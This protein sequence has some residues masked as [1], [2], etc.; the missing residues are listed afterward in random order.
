MVLVCV[1][2]NVYGL[3]F[4]G[5]DEVVVSIIFCLVLFVIGSVCVVFGLVEVVDVV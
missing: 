1:F 5:Y 4:M 3:V 2:S